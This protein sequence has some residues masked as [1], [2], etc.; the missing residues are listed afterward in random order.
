MKKIGPRVT[1]GTEKY[2]KENFKTLSAGAEYILNSAPGVA[3]RFMGIDL[4]DHFSKSEI[5]L[6]HDA[7]SPYFSSASSIIKNGVVMTP[8]IAGRHLLG[9]VED[10]ISLDNLDEKWSVD[11]EELLKK[12]KSMSTPELFFLEIWIYGQMSGKQYSS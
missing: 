8:S 11:T 12:L 4:R 3:R 10:A 6:L 1:E 5:N 7:S 2:L 9:N